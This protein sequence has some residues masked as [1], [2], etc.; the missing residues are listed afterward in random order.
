[1]KKQKSLRQKAHSPDK[2]R[3][4]ANKEYVNQTLNNETDLNELLESDWNPNTTRESIAMRGSLV[5]RLTL[6]SSKVTTLHDIQDISAPFGQY[7]SMPSRQVS[8]KESFKKGI[9]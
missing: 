7:S 9:N 4:L 6:N 5:R 8:A 2:K 3:K 1:M